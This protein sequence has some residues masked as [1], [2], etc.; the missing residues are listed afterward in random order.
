M[1]DDPLRPPPDILD[2]PLGLRPAPP[3]ETMEFDLDPRERQM[4]ARMR[5]RARMTQASILFWMFASTFVVVPLIFRHP[6]LWV[7][8]GATGIVAAV[9]GWFL[10]TNVPMPIHRPPHDPSQPYG[11]YDPKGPH[12]PRS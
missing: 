3:R 2:D 10:P 9:I 11:V 4:L 6:P 7:I 1:P 8:A 5:R 12:R